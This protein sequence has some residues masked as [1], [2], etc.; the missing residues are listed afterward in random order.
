MG[1]GR[2]P[3]GTAAR[4]LSNR[5]WPRNFEEEEPQLEAKRENDLKMTQARSGRDALRDGVSQTGLG[6]RSVKKGSRRLGQAWARD[7]KIPRAGPGAVD[8]VGPA[9]SN[10]APLERVASTRKTRWV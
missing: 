4:R 10:R 9:R 3:K 5:L 6:R 1:N 7:S 2:L 8:P